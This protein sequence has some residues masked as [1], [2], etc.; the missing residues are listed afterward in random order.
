MNQI[1]YFRIVAEQIIRLWVPRN[2]IRFYYKHVNEKAN[3]SHA[4]QLHCF[5]MT[6]RN[7][8]NHWLY[9]MAITPCSSRHFQGL[10]G[11]R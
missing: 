11:G 2:L 9:K 4:P 1:G 5:V 8:L 10:G 3:S 6:T 7:K